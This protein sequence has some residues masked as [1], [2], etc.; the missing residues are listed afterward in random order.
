MSEDKDICRV[1]DNE[2]E[3]VT[4]GLGITIRI[5]KPSS[6]SGTTTISIK[7]GSSEKSSSPLPLKGTKGGNS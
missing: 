4:G 6:T 3:D 2:L 1:D 5:S 7:S